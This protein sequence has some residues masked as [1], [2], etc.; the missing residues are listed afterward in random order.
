MY[1][2]GSLFVLNV[3]H[4][5]ELLYLYH[6]QKWNPA[7][8]CLSQLDY[9]EECNVYLELIGA[10]V[11][12][13]LS[14]LFINVAICRRP[15]YSNFAE[16]RAS[17]RQSLKILKEKLRENKQRKNV[18]FYYKFAIDAMEEV[19]V[20]PSPISIP[21]AKNIGFIVVSLVLTVIAI[22]VS[23][24]V[25]PD[26]IG[27]LF[28]ATLSTKVVSLALV[29]FSLVFMVMMSLG[30]ATVVRAVLALMVLVL[31][32]SVVM[33]LASDND[34]WRN[35]HSI[36]RVVSIF[37]SYFVVVNFL[38]FFMM[39]MYRVKAMLYKGILSMFYRL[40]FHMDASN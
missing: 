7:H 4:L 11:I 14:T 38:R 1:L 17:D 36:R 27:S 5:L 13:L 26:I 19:R 16:F 29:I 8:E 25:H 37:F 9:P 20:S 31:A 10:S 33:A 12:V 28:M 3:L 21:N 35:L 23:Y 34:I 15:D 2:V 22:A 6:T 32:S 18:T 24:M 39:T 40:Y 30:V